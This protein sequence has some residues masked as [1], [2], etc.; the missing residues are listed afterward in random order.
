MTSYL[1]QY[2]MLSDDTIRAY[3]RYSWSRQHR[4]RFYCHYFEDVVPEGVTV[5]HIPSGI[6]VNSREEIELRTP[7]GNVFMSG[8]IALG[9]NSPDLEQTAGDEAFTKFLEREYVGDD[10]RWRFFTGTTGLKFYECNG[11]EDWEL[12]ESLGPI[13]NQKQ[14]AEYLQWQ[15]ESLLH[16]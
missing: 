11:N 1:A 12:A 9:S 10:E 15:Y 16:W 5:H 7:R 4:L 3:E 2:G 13:Q 8:L 14:V 6:H